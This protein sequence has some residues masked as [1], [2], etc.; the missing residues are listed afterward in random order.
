VRE[1]DEFRGSTRPQILKG[2]ECM[3]I[4][5]LGDLVGRSGRKVV[6]ENVPALRE[7]FQLDAV[8]VNAENAA[9][10]FGI[11]PE[12]CEELFAADIDILTTGNHF[13]DQK[14]I[15]E[16]LEWQP[17]L[18][19]PV[20]Y[21]DG[22]PG[23]GIVRSVLRNGQTIIVMNVMGR[24]FMPPVEDP[25]DAIEE[26]LKTYRLKYDGIDAI[27]ID[28]HAETHSEKITI[29]HLADGKASGVF[30]THTHIPTADA[31]ILTRGTA[32]ISDVGMCGDYNSSVGMDL[33]ISL[34]RFRK[35]VP[36]PRLEPAMGSASLGGVYIETDERTGLAIKIQPFRWGRILEPT[37]F[38]SE[39]ESMF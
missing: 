20:N 29:A 22:T 3:K 35:V 38:L 9:G 12:I 7:K 4:L 36:M 37:C 1:Q 5:F 13:F 16:Y 28:V 19:R 33:D 8:I 27:I 34:A 24:L 39:K 23:K 32:F 30:G 15:A 31:R 6:T 25:F 17:C 26:A 14:Q 18:L 10:G 2:E 11:T 21:P